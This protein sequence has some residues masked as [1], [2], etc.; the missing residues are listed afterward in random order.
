MHVRKVNGAVPDPTATSEAVGGSKS[1]LF[2]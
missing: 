1:A 2:A